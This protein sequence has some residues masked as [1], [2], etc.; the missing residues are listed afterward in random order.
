MKK[1]ELE[2]LIENK[3]RSI[4]KEDTNRNFIFTQNGIILAG[5][6]LKLKVDRE[7][8]ITEPFTDTYIEQ[9]KH[10]NDIIKML[11]SSG[12]IKHHN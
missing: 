12:A 4:L 5:F 8:K 10:G 11:I 9:F 2:T 3:V 7:F 1:S 6:F